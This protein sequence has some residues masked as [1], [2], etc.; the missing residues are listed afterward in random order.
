MAEELT[1]APVE[2]KDE[3]VEQLLNS[4][5]DAYLKK[6]KRTRIISYSII[7]FVVLALAVAIIVMSSIKIDLRPKFITEGANYQVYINKQMKENISADPSTK[8]KYDKFN[9]IFLN[10]FNTQYLTA[11]F[12]GKLGGYKVEECTQEFFYSNQ[13]SATGINS[14]LN[15]YLGDNYVKITYDQPINITNSNGKPCYTQFNS[16]YELKFEELYFNLN[17]LDAEQDLVFYLG[18][19]GYVTKGNARIVKI[20]VRANT[21]DLYNLFKD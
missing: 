16:N 7:L 19:Y 18:G 5:S 8:Q 11:L 3:N 15:N 20:T 4:V 13:T 14:D 21:F 9:S 12:T 2:E 10:S 17:T 6:R 1:Q